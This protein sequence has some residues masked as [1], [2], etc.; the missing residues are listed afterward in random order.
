MF[1]S[2]GQNAESLLTG[3]IGRE[4]FDVVELSPIPW[5]VAEEMEE[6]LVF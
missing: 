5:W 1:R 6:G 2:K 3:L 4:R